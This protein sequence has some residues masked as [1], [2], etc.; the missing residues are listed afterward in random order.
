MR[1][2]ES[3][4]PLAN[5]IMVLINARKS[6]AEYR[7]LFKEESAIAYRDCVTMYRDIESLKSLDF[8]S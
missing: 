7:V 8:T 2:L 4:L 3:D 5:V 6:V 1:L